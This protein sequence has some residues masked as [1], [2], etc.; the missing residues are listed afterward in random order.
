MGTGDGPGTVSVCTYCT[1]HNNTVVDL[2]QSVGTAVL[3]RC[4]L[5]H[6]TALITDLGTTALHCSEK[7]G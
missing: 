1:V 7:E 6:F 3:L 4:T 5:L 2:L